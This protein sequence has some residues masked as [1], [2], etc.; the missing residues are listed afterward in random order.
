MILLILSAVFGAA[1]GAYVR[2]RPLAVVLA[3]VLAGA[4]RGVLHLTCAQLGRTV[5]P[6]GWLN[7]LEDLIASP[8]AGYTPMI[9]VAGSAAL[10]AALLCL[11]L[12]QR[13]FGSFWLPNGDAVR[14]RDRTGRYR[15]VDHMVETR[16]V[17]TAAEARMRSVYEG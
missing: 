3:L 1:L 7:A 4:T 14:L 8:L 10:F 5:A 11:I 9:A 15:R 16:T 6:P 2:P 13:P 12:D 17:Q